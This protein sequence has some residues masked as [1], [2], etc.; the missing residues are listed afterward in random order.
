VA[1]L[2]FYGLDKDEIDSYYAR[3]DSMTLVDAQR[4]I[5]EHFPLDNLVFVLIEK[6]SEIEGAAHKYAPRVDAK[7]IEAPGY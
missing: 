3:I 4:V 5:K 1:Q 2:E 7:S 6:A